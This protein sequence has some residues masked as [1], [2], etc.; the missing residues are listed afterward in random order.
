MNCPNGCIGCSNPICVC[1]ENP[2]PQN[3][4][5]LKNCKK[6]KSVEWGECVIECTNNQQCEQSCVESFKEQYESCPCQVKIS[7]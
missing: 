2:S 5:N 3:E 7:I 4:E 6:E 1:G